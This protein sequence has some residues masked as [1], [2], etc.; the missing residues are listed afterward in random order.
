MLLNCILP[1]CYNYGFVRVNL[2]T[3]H[4]ILRVR[5]IVS[6]YYEKEHDTK[7]GF[8]F[9]VELLLTLGDLSIIL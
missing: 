7:W 3:F 2:C 9:A 5:V 1:I 8:K 6:F 4:F